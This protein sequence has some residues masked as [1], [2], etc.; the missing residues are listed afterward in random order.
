MHTHA[1]NYSFENVR[2]NESDNKLDYLSIPE[3]L[4][5]YNRYLLFSTWEILEQQLQQVD[6]YKSPDIYKAL[7]ERVSIVFDAW[8]LFRYVGRCC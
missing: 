5:E 6:P 2:L 8:L 7:D 1:T 4:L 3:A